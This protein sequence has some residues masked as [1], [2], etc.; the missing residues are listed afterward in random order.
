MNFGTGVLIHGLRRD[1]ADDSNLH[2]LFDFYTA[3]QL[4]GLGKTV[5][6]GPEFSPGLD[7]AALRC[8]AI[9][10]IYQS[11]ELKPP[12]R[13]ALAK[14]QEMLKLLAG[15][16]GEGRPLSSATC[17]SRDQGTRIHHALAGYFRAA[18]KNW[19]RTGAHAFGAGRLPTATRHSGSRKG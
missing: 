16:L 9:D 14:S 4:Y 17:V 10:R 7:A 8:P 3:A 1:I 15:S 11:P 6:P 18:S 12:T 19:L 2:Q 5:S 13:K